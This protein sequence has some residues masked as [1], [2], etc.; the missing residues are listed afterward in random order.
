VAPEAALLLPGVIVG[1]NLSCH[2]VAVPGGNVV[3][4]TP[5]Y[6]PFLRVPGITGLQRH[7]ALLSRSSDGHYEVDWDAF[8]SQVDDQTRLFILCNPHN[9]VGRVW[10]REELERMA[11]VC[12]RKGVVICSDEIHCD[13][14]YPGHPHVPIASLDKEISRNT[15]TLMAPTKS[16]NIAGLQCSFAI[17][18][19]EKLRQRLEASMRGLVM[20]VNLVGQ[21]AALVAYRDGGEWWSRCWRTCRPTASSSM[22]T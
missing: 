13:L 22:I 17:V 19:D 8:E 21:T 20:W 5:V 1:L 12:L 9:P 11:Q 3:V 10:R 16:F 6:P 2:A 15:V 4:Q 18:Q 14:V 7:D